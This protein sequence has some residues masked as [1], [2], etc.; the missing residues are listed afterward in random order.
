MIIELQFV[1]SFA[2][3]HHRV[4]GIP[5]SPGASQEWNHLTTDDASNI[6]VEWFAPSPSGYDAIDAVVVNRFQ[7]FL[8]RQ[9]LLRQTLFFDGILDTALTV[10][11]AE[12]VISC[13][14]AGRFPPSTSYRRRCACTWRV[15][16]S[17]KTFPM[18]T[19]CEICGAYGVNGF[20]CLLT[21]RCWRSA[22]VIDDGRH[23]RSGL[24]SKRMQ[25]IHRVGL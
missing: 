14:N 23:V 8:P 21:V 3:R 18:Q 7:M 20:C 6:I 11:H 15:D 25:Q 22:H 17:G 2:H 4:D 13:P 5:S 10:T 12:D 19:P 1:V 9:R 24:F 16:G